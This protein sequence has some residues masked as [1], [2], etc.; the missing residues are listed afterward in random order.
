MPASDFPLPST[1]D[2]ILEVNGSPAL[3]HPLWIKETHENFSHLRLRS[4]PTLPNRYR[5]SNY[6]DTTKI[7]TPKLSSK[8]SKYWASV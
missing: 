8:L 1:F 2:P 3:T 7:K 4:N 5:A 6:Q